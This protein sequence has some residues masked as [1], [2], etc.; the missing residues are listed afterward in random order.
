MRR[1]FNIPMPYPLITA[2]EASTM[3]VLDAARGARTPS[4]GCTYRT[5]QC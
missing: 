1:S 2:L 4:D 5:Q 3:L